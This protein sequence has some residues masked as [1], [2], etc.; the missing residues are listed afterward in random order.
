MTLDRILFSAAFVTIIVTAVG[1]F[2]QGGT[3]A[4]ASKASAKQTVVPTPSLERIV[5]VGQRSMDRS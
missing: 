3:A 2:I 5:V 1:D 4:T